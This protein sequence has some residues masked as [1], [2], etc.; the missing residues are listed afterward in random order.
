MT[1][2]YVINLSFITT[3]FNDAKYLNRLIQSIG[4]STSLRHECVI[5]DDGSTSHRAR[6]AFD[7]L[8]PI[9]ENQILKKIRIENSGLAEARN[10]GI[11]Q[12]S[13]QV[14]RFVDTDDYLTVGSTDLL[15]EVMERRN[16][17]LAIGDYFLW[18]ENHEI[19]NWPLRNN[20]SITVKEWQELPNLWEREFSIP[21]HSA[22][23][24]NLKTL[25]ESGM[26]SKEDW[27]FWSKLSKET[28]PSFL[29]YPVC[30]YVLHQSNMTSIR[31][32]QSSLY[33]I[34]AF[35]K[36]KHERMFKSVTEEKMLEAHYL[37]TYYDRIPDLEKQN[38]REKKVYE[39][40]S[41][42]FLIQLLDELNE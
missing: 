29:D 35:L 18:D 22:I 11:K 8:V 25:F 10:I 2:D 42:K 36:L 16:A 5:V 24:K 33:W 39:S 3:T 21:I 17:N 6:R 20:N 41:E 28:H 13:G 32:L 19:V 38:F 23:F 9:S 4:M 34:E 37:R 27:V 26:R 15:I 30:G 40:E 1:S 14:I 7:E 31:T 12:A